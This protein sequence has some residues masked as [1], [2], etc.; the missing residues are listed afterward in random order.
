MTR[1]LRGQSF[2]RT[3]PYL[4]VGRIMAARIKTFVANRLLP[5][6]RTHTEILF[7][8]AQSLAFETNHLHTHDSMSTMWS[9]R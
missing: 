1:A 7:F 5:Q 3:R 2:S 8:Y 4:F 6:Y 9:L